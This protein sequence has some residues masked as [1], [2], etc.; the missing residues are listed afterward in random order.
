M[1]ANPL[2]ANSGIIEYFL[3]LNKPVVAL[4]TSDA[5]FNSNWYND[6]KLAKTFVQNIIR[7]SQKKIKFTGGGLTE[8]NR[9]AF[10]SVLFY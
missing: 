1:L 2:N 5:I 7:R 9:A 3:V 6:P 10:T 4:H 8:I